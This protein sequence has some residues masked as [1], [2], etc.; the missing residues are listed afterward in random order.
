[1]E[2]KQNVFLPQQNKENL[3]FGNPMVKGTVRTARPLENFF[4][5]PATGFP[6]K[7]SCILHW[8]IM[9]NQSI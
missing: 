8:G 3:T 6:S 2:S 7:P 5:V 9:W 4:M 1:M